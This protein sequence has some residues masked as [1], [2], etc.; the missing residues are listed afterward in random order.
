MYE[1]LS[2]DIPSILHLSMDLK[3]KPLFNEIKHISLRV[4]ANHRTDTSALYC[5]TIAI[6]AAPFCN[7]SYFRNSF[8]QHN[9][10]S[11][12][13]QFPGE[14]GNGVNLS[15][16]ISVLPTELLAVAQNALQSFLFGIYHCQR[17]KQTT[18]MAQNHVWMTN[19]MMSC[20]AASAT[21]KSFKIHA[22]YIGERAVHDLK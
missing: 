9:W 18:T 11:V 13:R 21:S 14:G 12:P 6:H 1:N 2:Y 7:K 3:A 22:L 20:W 5:C 10:S 4:Q 8:R 19:S 16:L 15:L 17:G